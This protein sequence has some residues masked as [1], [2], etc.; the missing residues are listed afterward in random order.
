MQAHSAITCLIDFLNII[1][2]D[3]EN[4]RLIEV[5]FLELKKAFDATDYKLSNLN[6]SYRTI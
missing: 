2:D 6:I 1:F 5:A 3:M 4:G